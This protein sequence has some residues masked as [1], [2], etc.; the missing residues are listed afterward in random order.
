MHSTHWLVSTRD[1]VASQKTLGTITLGASAVA[2]SRA[3]R[4]AE[5]PPTATDVW[6]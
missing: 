1:D 4:S 3:K 5:R 6:S 2:Y